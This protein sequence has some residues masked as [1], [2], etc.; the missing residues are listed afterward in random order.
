MCDFFAGRLIVSHHRDDAAA[1]KLIEDIR[2]GRIEHVV[3]VETMAD[4]LALLSLPGMPD[5]FSFELHLLAVPEGEEIWKINYLRFFYQ[6]NLIDLTARGNVSPAM[7][8]AIGGSD[9]HLL[10]VPDATV[11]LCPAEGEVKVV[12]DPIHK[13]Y[14]K[15][16]GLPARYASSGSGVT[17]AVVDTGVAPQLGIA[18]ANG[19]RAFHEEKDPGRAFDLD[20][21][22]GHGTVVA[23][24]VHDLA[25]DAEIMVLK[26][27]D[28][29]P[30]SE[31]N[32][33]AA[34]LAPERADIVNLSLA[35]GMPSPTARP[36]GGTR[37]TRR[38]ARFL[39]RPSTSSR[40]GPKR[41]SSL[42]R[43]SGEAQ[44]GL[45]RALHRCGGGWCDRLAVPPAGVQQLWRQGPPGRI[46]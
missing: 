7:W 14:K 22:N 12:F 21:E 16:L 33:L 40:S 32:V 1:R 42:P 2:D 31:W 41:S 10:V 23:G 18:A 13:D 45:S 37:R 9:S 6:H 27:G 28:R 24:I 8:A 35:F 39:S 25:P 11:T 30:L 29:N 5:G 17:V 26:V 3:Y 20:D 34:L 19:S 15:L 43:E 44:A 46:S 38:A 36:V 4:K